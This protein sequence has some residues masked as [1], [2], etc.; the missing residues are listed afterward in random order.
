[1]TSSRSTFQKNNSVISSDDDEHVEMSLLTEGIVS[2]GQEAMWIEEDESVKAVTPMEQQTGAVTSVPKRPRFSFGFH[3]KNHQSQSVPATSSSAVD[4]TSENFQYK[5]KVNQKLQEKKVKKAVVLLPQTKFSGDEGAVG[6][7]N[8]EGLVQANDAQEAVLSM[9]RARSLLHQAL[10]TDGKGDPTALKDSEQL[11]KMAFAEAIQARKLAAG[12][13]GETVDDDELTVLTQQGKS[14]IQEHSK[15]VFSTSDSSD[16]DISKAKMTKSSQQHAFWMSK[17][18]EEYS[19]RARYYLESILPKAFDT[20]PQHTNAQENSDSWSQGDMSSLGFMGPE[21]VRSRKPVQALTVVTSKNSTSK[22]KVSNDDVSISSLNELLDTPRNEAKAR[23]SDAESSKPVPFVNIGGDQQKTVKSGFFGGIF[24]LAAA[25]AASKTDAIIKHTDPDSTGDDVSNMS[26]S[27]V[28]MDDTHSVMASRLGMEEEAALSP[29]NE[30]RE[31][32]KTWASKKPDLDTIASNEEE[33]SEIT[34]SSSK[35]S[36]EISKSD[37]EESTLVNGAEEEAAEKP[38]HS[39]ANLP[40]NEPAKKTSNQEAHCLKTTDNDSPENATV[41]P[42]CLHLDVEKKAEHIEE[43]AS[44]EDIPRLSN[45]KSNSDEGTNQDDKYKIIGEKG[46]EN[47]SEEDIAEKEDATITSLDEESQA[48]GDIKENQ[49][50]LKEDIEEGKRNMESV[51]TKEVK[52]PV[53]AEGEAASPPQNSSPSNELKTPEKEGG[54]EKPTRSSALKR[55]KKLFSGKK[56]TKKS[57]EEENLS[58]SVLKEHEQE[59]EKFE[60]VDEEALIAAMEKAALMASE[61]NKSAEDAPR[62][63]YV[64]HHGAE[65]NKATK[66]VHST[67][68]FSVLSPVPADAECPPLEEVLRSR[69]NRTSREVESDGNVENRQPRMDHHTQKYNE[70]NGIYIRVTNSPKA[71][72]ATTR[73]IVR[74]S[75]GQKDAPGTDGFGRKLPETASNHRDPP[76]KEHQ[77]ASKSPGPRRRAFSPLRRN[78]SQ[79]AEKNL[80]PTPRRRKEQ[81]PFSELQSEENEKR[82]IAESS[83]DQLPVK[84]PPNHSRYEQKLVTNRLFAIDSKDSSS[85]QKKNPT[86]FDKL[87][88]KAS[89]LDDTE[90]NP[91]PPPP[92]PPATAPKEP[93]RQLQLQIETS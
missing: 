11:A 60:K 13:H 20:V 15:I 51:D 48:T 85:L 14:A 31:Q 24:G 61:A 42:E 2:E 59:E 1:M 68:P 12:V 67:V 23:T 91:P 87:E 82:G 78:K 40:K 66:S 65:P 62:M 53:T 8:V 89:A 56:H 75:N 43:P 50:P 34:E 6:K 10:Q 63:K 28:K 38:P 88:Q 29:N 4:P 19:T 46:E 47:T 90:N 92:P 33:E 41:A 26:G 76:Q 25:A 37:G 22:S 27:A 73:N 84:D 17:A 18:M 80:A 39:S 21:V 83:S 86:I 3:K 81:K 71:K 35:Q 54:T 93:R 55:I 79:K 74:P 57:R 5:T 30:L 32:K 44:K 77:A 72:C 7:S 52:E 49:S 9:N 45:L 64:R 70:D 36:E 69:I 58:P 16:E